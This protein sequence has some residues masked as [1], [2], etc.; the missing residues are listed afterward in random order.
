MANVRCCSKAAMEVGAIKSSKARLIERR[1]VRIQE[2]LAE[3][4]SISLFS[5]VS[6]ISD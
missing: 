2:S 4:V 6:R 5:K 3:P 1:V